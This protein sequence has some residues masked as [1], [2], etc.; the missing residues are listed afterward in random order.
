MVRAPPAKR[1]I[2]PLV[3]LRMQLFVVSATYTELLASTA[4]AEG[5]ARVAAVVAPEK[6]QP[7]PVPPPAMPLTLPPV[8]L[9]TQ[10]RLKSVM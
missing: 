6:A 3:T 2:A 4:T 9:R 10:L 7:V 5:P 1:L 8:T